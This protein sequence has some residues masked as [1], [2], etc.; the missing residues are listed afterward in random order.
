MFIQLPPSPEQQLIDFVNGIF[1]NSE[2]QLKQLEE[3]HINLFQ[4]VYNPWICTTQELFDFMA[5]HSGQ[6]WITVKQL[7]DMSAI[8]QDYIDAMKKIMKDNYQKLVPP[9]PVTINPDE[10]VTINQ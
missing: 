9:V 2:Y 3:S 6:L 1:I 10:T 8:T 4:R 5:S 7:F